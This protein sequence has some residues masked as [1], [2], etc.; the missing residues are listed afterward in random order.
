MSQTHYSPKGTSIYPNW[1]DGDSLYLTWG[2]QGTDIVLSE[3]GWTGVKFVRDPRGKVYEVE[4]FRQAVWDMIEK[5]IIERGF[6]AGLKNETTGEYKSPFCYIPPHALD[7]YFPKAEAAPAPDL[8]PEVTFKTYRTKSKIN[9][10]HFDGTEACA[11]RFARK[12]EA[13]ASIKF[14]EGK[15]VIVIRND[16]G[17]VRMDEV[18][19]GDFI[20]Q[21]GDTLLKVH[22][23]ADIRDNWEQ[24]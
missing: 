3:H 20:E 8:S 9:L 11:L 5:K 17:N 13:R 1:I 4:A 14:L 19:A 24:A 2:T 18:R 12:F 16:A 15:I 10:W 23:A 22:T 7:E 6:S 21:Y